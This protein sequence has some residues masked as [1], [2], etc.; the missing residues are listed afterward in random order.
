MEQLYRVYGVLIQ[1]EILWNV[2]CNSMTF[3]YMII[4]I[5]WE[6]DENL[7]ITPHFIIIDYSPTCAILICD[8]FS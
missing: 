8:L 4:A 5:K 2:Q 7:C 6:N 1:Y 3:L